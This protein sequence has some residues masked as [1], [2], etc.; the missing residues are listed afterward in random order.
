M[1]RGHACFDAAGFRPQ[2]SGEDEGVSLD[3]EAAGYVA[4]A[5][6]EMDMGKAVDW[7]RTSAAATD[8]GSKTLKRRML[9]AVRSGDIQLVDADPTH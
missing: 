6:G 4:N 5:S 3:A 2:E 7:S 1:R 8:D 9:E